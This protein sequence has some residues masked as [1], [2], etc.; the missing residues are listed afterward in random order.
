[1]AGLEVVRLVNEPTAAS[2]AYGL[3]QMARG[4]DRGLRPWRRNLRYI[5]PQHQ[6]RDFE[7]L[8]TNGDTHLG[9]DDFDRRWSISLLVDRPTPSGATVTS[10]NSARLAAEDGK[11][12]PK[13]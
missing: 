9:G 2:L 8:A 1:M 12:A 5:D 7:V 3:N 6:G 10:W 13:R 4:Q 11:K